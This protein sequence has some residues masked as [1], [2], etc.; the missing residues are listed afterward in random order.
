MLSIPFL[1]ELFPEAAVVV[2]TR[3]PY[4]V[5][6]SHLDQPWAPS[7]LGQVLNWLE[8]VYQRWLA[9]SGRPWCIGQPGGWIGGWV[10]SWHAWRAGTPARLAAARM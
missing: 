9:W 4:Q 5:T 2:I 1:R 10:S 7:D 6:A 8:P 3:H